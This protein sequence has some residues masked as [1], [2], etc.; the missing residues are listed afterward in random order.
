VS[1]PGAS[2]AQ[3][4]LE[5][6]QSSSGTSSVSENSTP[7]TEKTSFEMQPPMKSHV[8]S[9]GILVGSVSLAS[10]KVVVGGSVAL[11]KLGVPAIRNSARSSL[12]KS[13]LSGTPLDRLSNNV[14]PAA[15]A[16]LVQRQEADHLQKEIEAR[17]K[18]AHEEAERLQ[19]DM[20]ARGK[21]AQ[22]EAE[23]VRKEQ[24]AKE[25]IEQEETVRFKKEKEAQVRAV[26]A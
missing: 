13:L 23:R 8:S 3:K 9:K 10:S 7:T 25:R 19:K 16:S 5:P 22:E 21:T 12:A 6:P 11:V 14:L 24:E 18:A 15:A 2:V 4:T 20:E 1:K 17:G 26:R